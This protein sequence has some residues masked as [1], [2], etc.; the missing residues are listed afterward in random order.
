[1]L[2]SSVVWAEVRPPLGLD[3]YRPIPQDNPVTAEKARLG[4]K[5][6]GDRLLSRDGSL[7][8]KGCHQPRKAFTD[9]RARAVG[10]YGRQG[11]R[12]V[13][14]LVNRT[15]GRAFFWDGRTS[16]LE[17]Q[18]LKPIE[19]KREMDMTVQEVV[20]RLK[21]K[22]KYR[23]MFHEAFGGEVN[24]GDLARALASYVRTIY[25][26]DSPLDRYI[27]GKSNALSAQQRHGLRIFRGKGNCTACH[28][29]PTFTD[30]EFHNTGVAWRD[31]KL[32]DEGRF[33]V[34]GKPEDQ[35]AFKTPTLR[36]VARTAPY[37]HDGSLA[38]LKDVIDFYDDGGRKNP[39]LDPE[40]RP[41]R[42]TKEEKTELLV[43]LKSLTGTVEDGF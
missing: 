21:R 38:T 34:T 22:R 33:T 10:V 5:L 31:G 18:V 19:S 39:Y 13:P 23:R 14:T 20:E 35:G 30:E 27:Y 40:I 29:G 24:S 12:S 32:L 6:F 41:R 28:A 37:M 25:S 4:K 3:L 15:Y 26:G 7:A 9:G 16:T 42:L 17:E 8:C 43:F 2:T 11:P 36:E 1:M